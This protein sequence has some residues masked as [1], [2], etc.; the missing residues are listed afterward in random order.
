LHE[1]ASIMQLRQQFIAF[2]K[3][4]ADLSTKYGPG[5]PRMKALQDEM[6]AVRKAYEKEM[7]EALATFEK[8]YQEIVDNEKSLRAL[9]EQQKN[10]AIELSKIEVEYRPLLRASQ[11]NEKMYGLV[12]S[13]QKE[14][15]ITGPM[16]TNNV[17]VLERA[18]VPGA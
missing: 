7:N 9:M 15:D 8:A 14:I 4:Y 5:H 11:Q 18:V 6:D 13:R 17:R 10:E 16:R 2:S 1:A 12:S 3:E